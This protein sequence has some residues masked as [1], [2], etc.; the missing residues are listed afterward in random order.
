[1]EELLG[2]ALAT[3]EVGYL[4]R[5]G[6]RLKDEDAAE[7]GPELRRLYE[8][9][10]RT[11]PDIVEAARPE[12]SP[13]HR[14]FEWQDDVAAELYRHTQARSLVRSIIIEPAG[15]NPYPQGTRAFVFVRH[16]G[17]APQTPNPAGMVPMDVVAVDPVALGQVILEAERG[18]RAWQQ[19]YNRYIGIRE[20]Q[21]RFGGVLDF[22]DRT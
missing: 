17:P 10:Q 19:Q 15:P 7:I 12:A 4:A 2:T 5:P 16:P 21:Q 1:M 11:A 18:L 3:P 14:F 20:F 13:L 8:E 9:G 22:L 6:S